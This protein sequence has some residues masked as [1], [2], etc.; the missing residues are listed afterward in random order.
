[1]ADKW[2]MIVDV[3]KCENCHNCTLSVKDEYVD[4]NFPGYSAPQPK[5][6][7][8]WIKIT[9]KVR[10]DGHLTDVAYLPT[11]CNH[12]DNA[13]CVAAGK[14]AVRKRAD[15]IVI[16]DPKA[17]KGRKDIVASCPYGA[18]TWNDELGLPQ[19]W[20]F[21]AHLI[22]QGWKEPRASQACPTGALSAVK[23]SDSA[24]KVKAKA[25]GLEVLQPALN[26][27]PRV[28]YR[29]LHRFSKAFVGGSVVA[30]VGSGVGI[31][32]VAGAEVQLL[33]ELKLM[34]SA[35]TDAFGDF[36]FDG[37]EPD[38]KQYTVRIDAREFGR[39]EVGVTVRDSINLGNVIVAV[40]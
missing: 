33:Q 19:H 36:K 39:A 37:L 32:C 34:Q 27:R 29:S 21:D 35:K 4:N 16:I 2:N 3:A 1:M 9:R 14:G 10:G 18:I 17:A 38:G 40:A 28:Y 25:E 11:M 31:D 26:T 6:G 20:T 13:P 30:K 22:D 8:D 7:A 24:M 23:C 12:C 15:G 5:H